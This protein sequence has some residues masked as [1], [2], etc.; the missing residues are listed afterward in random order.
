MLSGLV[1]TLSLCLG[2][3]LGE[4]GPKNVTS[5]VYYLQ[6]NFSGTSFFDNFYFE[7]MDDPTHGMNSGF[8]SDFVRELF[9]RTSLYRLRQ[10]R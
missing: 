1:F 8:M 2:A 5:T 7:T 9:D 4:A 3:V 10:L 6:D